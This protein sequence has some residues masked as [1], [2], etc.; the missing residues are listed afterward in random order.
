VNNINC[1][2]GD[3]DS[4]IWFGSNGSGLCKYELGSKK[5]PN[6]RFIHYSSREGLSNDFVTSI[7]EDR[8]G[9]IWIGTYGGGV[10]IYDGRSF[11]HF[12]ED[13][14]M[15][16]N[17][18]TSILE[19]KN[20]DIW[21]GTFGGGVCQFEKHTPAFPGGRFTYFTIEDNLNT[22]NFRQRN[23]VLTRNNNI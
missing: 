9:I 2:T 3:K 20:G 16:N 18:I 1:I 13:Q 21:F 7:T 15:S 6:G 11:K 22:K 8:N 12:N 23:R 17:I 5:Y 10:N 14:G 19:S 4:S